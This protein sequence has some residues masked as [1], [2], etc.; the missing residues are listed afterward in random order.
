L[1]KTHPKA[2]S[3]DAAHW[4]SATSTAGFSTPAEPNSQ[5]SLKA[6]HKFKRY[7]QLEKTIYQFQSDDYIVVNHSLPKAGFMLNV[8][9]FT[10]AGSRIPL[11][12]NLIQ[13]SQEGRLLIPLYALRQQ[14]PS[15]NYILNIHAYHR[16]SDLCNQ[17]LRLV[18]LQG[19]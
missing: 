13:V 10:F 11:S 2:P 5:Q 8:S 12:N 3:T 16:D 14:L 19:T 7:F 6:K 15:G 1:E 9:L 17:R 4:V 18:L